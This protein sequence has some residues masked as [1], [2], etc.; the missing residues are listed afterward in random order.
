MTPSPNEQS[1]AG[2]SCRLLA[3]PKVRGGLAATIAILAIAYLG[4]LFAPHDPSDIVGVPFDIAG[5]STWLGTDY[6]GQDT[7]SRVLW[8]GRSV[9]WMATL[10][11]LIATVLG[12]AI[13]TFAAYTGG[14]VDL[15]VG[16]LNDVLLAFPLIVLVILFLSMLGHDPVLIVQVVAIG[17]LPTVTRLSRSVALA[18]IHQ[19]YVAWAELA[20]TPRYKILFKEVLPNIT[21]PLIVQFGAL[22][23]WS[24]GVIAGLSF[25]GFGIQPPNADWGLMVNENRSG[26][27]IAPWGTLAPIIMIAAFAL[28]VNSLTEAA[29][30]VLGVG[31]NL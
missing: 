4:P 2:I 16:W 14:L 11:S 15:A 10:A 22:L 7:F 21:T 8:G 9:V 25:L 1:E 19:E 3:S 12:A 29:G 20:G 28:A 27:M 13:G 17:W 30:K 6:L 24:I 23:T 26:L 18:A 31:E 5:A